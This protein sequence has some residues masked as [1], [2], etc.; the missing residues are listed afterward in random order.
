MRLFLEF[1]DLVV[2]G[3]E[4]TFILVLNG[5]LLDF[6]AVLVLLEFLIVGL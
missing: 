1:F 4:L 2:L 3:L 6:E 5:L